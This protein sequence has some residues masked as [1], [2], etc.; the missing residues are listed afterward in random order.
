MIAAV[1]LVLTI[2]A[3]IVSIGFN[4]RQR[5]WRND[6]KAE[7]ERKDNE[8][9]AEQ[10]RR[11]QAPPE[12]F[13]V[14]GNPGPILVNGGQ[15]SSQGPFM[16][17]WGLVTVVNRTQ[18]PMKITPLRL[19]MAGVEWPVQSISFHLKSNQQNRSDRISMRGND[20]E[21]YELHFLLRD[22]KRATGDGTLWFTSDNRPEEFSVAVRFP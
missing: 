6:D 21:D 7:Q 13:N 17:V 4:L 5:K 2:I 12:F 8:R 16:D 22:D 11:E 1:G 15:H 9:E 19:V 20:K 14:S 18:M 3:L 10:R